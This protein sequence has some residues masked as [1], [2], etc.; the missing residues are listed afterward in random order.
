M[1]ACDNADIGN[2]KRH[3]HL[4]PIWEHCTDKIAE[5]YLKQIKK[6]NP[7][8]LSRQFT[9]DMLGNPVIKEYDGFTGSA[10][11]IQYIGVL[12]NLIKLFGPL[13]GLKICEFGGGYGGQA[14]TIMDIFHVKEYD[15]IDLPQVCGLINRYN[16]QVHTFTRPTGLYYDLFISNYA[17]S[18]MKENTEIMKHCVLKSDHGYITTNTDLIKMPIPFTEWPDVEGERETNKIIIW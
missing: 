4:T 16:P 15:V 11:T 7:W 5:G 13:D 18:E 17:L 6:D 1:D 12:S 9:N 3:P 8:L 10:S 2:F 14:T